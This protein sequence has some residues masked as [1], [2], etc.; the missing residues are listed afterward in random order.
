MKRQ[1]SVLLL[2]NGELREPRVVTR[3]ARKADVILCADGGARHARTLGFVPDFIV[4]DMDSL[5]HSLPKAWAATVYWKDLDEN[6]SDLDKA[7]DFV[8]VLGRSRVYVAGALGGGLDHELVNL[9]VL[10]K[11]AARLDLV[12]VGGGQARML[13]QGR[14]RLNLKKGQRFSLLAVPSARVTLTGALYNMKAQRLIR[15]SLGL[16]NRSSGMSVL[17]VHQGRIWFVLP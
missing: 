1:R 11:R 10:E 3:L 4:G 5:P 7:L 17:T 6:R 15:G 9:S 16:G 12:I 13:G 14:H 8:K 2:L